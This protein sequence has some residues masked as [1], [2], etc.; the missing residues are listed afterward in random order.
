MATNIAETS[1]TVPGVVYVVDAGVVKQK[2]YN[3]VTGMDSLDVVPISK[4]VGIRVGGG[5][6][7][8][9][10]CVCVCGVLTVHDHAA[11][12]IH[13][14][15]ISLLVQDTNTSIVLMLYHIC[16]LSCLYLIISSTN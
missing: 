1:V 15:M 8:L 7:V 3:P 6:G 12:V 9:C 14:F 16:V 10:V 13:D 11:L 5:G 2:E 4:Y